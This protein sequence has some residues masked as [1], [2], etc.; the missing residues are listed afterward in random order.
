MWRTILSAL[1]M[2]NIRRRLCFTPDLRR[3]RVLLN[4]NTK[5][6]DVIRLGQVGDSEELDL[7]TTSNTRWRTRKCGWR[8]DYDREGEQNS[9]VRAVRELGERTADTFCSTTRKIRRGYE[10]CTTSIVPRSCACHYVTNLMYVVYRDIHVKPRWWRGTGR[11]VHGS[12]APE[13]E[14]TLKIML[15]Y[16]NVWE[17]NWMSDVL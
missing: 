5:N 14:Y 7:S 2:K 3:K 8:P 12:T 11:S 1:Q 9:I 16:Q 10:V 17:Q 13:R 6:S 4:M 15:V